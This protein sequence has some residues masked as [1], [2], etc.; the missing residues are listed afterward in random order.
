MKRIQLLSSLLFT[1][2][3]IP[4]AAPAVRAA[5]PEVSV[6]I[7]DRAHRDYHVWSAGEDHV[8]RG[9]LGE[10]RLPYRAYQKLRAKQQRDYWKW[11]HAHPEY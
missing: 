10:R 5:G 6:R 3:L 7:Y 2:V 9:Y 11:R 1:A 8:Y 4:F